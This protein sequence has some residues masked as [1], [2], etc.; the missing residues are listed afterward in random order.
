M[1]LDSATYTVAYG[2]DNDLIISNL[3]TISKKKIEFNSLIVGVTY[4]DENYLT[5]NV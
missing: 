2:L 4:C 5:V 3:I 1:T